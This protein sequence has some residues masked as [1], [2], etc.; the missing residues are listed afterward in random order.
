[1]LLAE[2]ICLLLVNIA[3]GA[4]GLIPSALLTAVNLHA[5]GLYGGAGLTIVGEILGAVLGFY[6]YRY[7]FS[8]T[9]PNW[10]QH[11]FW[12][13]FQQRSPKQVVSLVIGLRLLPFMPSGLVT[14]GASLTQISGKAFSMASTI[15][16]LPAVAFEL[17]AVYGI[18]LWVP[19][20]IQMSLFGIFLLMAVLSWVLST[21]TKKIPQSID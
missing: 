6:L 2:W 1:M 17:L 3:V 19:R 7:G 10:L 12:K 20:S 4:I 13:K 21:K 8:K 11:R 14:A 15:G 9:N 18:I 5:F 16:K